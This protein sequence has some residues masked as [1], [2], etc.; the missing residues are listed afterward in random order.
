VGFAR[1]VRASVGDLDVVNVVA[2]R[3]DAGA[4]AV[5]RVKTS[6][7]SGD[8]P[9]SKR[10]VVERLTGLVAPRVA[11]RESLP[12][13]VGAAVLLFVALWAW[14]SDSSLSEQNPEAVT[15]STSSPVSPS[16]RTP[17]R[18]DT[19]R[20]RASPAA[21]TAS[22]TRTLLPFPWVTPSPPGKGRG[23]GKWK[24]DDD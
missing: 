15:A 24:D 9:G 18:G 14:C 16:E 8:E 4:D 7:E 20:G 22:S 10:S 13:L 1:T 3:P 6:P 19:G 2:R 12:P 23:H 11:R 21:T 17:G 5:A